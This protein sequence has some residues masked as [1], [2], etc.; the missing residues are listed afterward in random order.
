MIAIRFTC[1]LAR[2]QDEG[3]RY[4]FGGMLAVVLCVEA[5]PARGACE[6]FAPG[7]R[8]G[9]ATA[10]GLDEASGIA[11][12][13]RNAGILWTHND[14]A[15]RE[16]YALGPKG[17]LLA[18]YFLPQNVID[19]EDIAVGPGPQEGVSYLY[20]GDIGGN[21]GRRQ[22]QI[23]RIPEPLVDPGWHTHPRARGFAGADKFA[24][25]YPDGLYDAESLMVDPVSRDVFVVTKQAQGARVYRANV[26][27][28]SDGSAV[29][30]DFVRTVPFA[31]ASAADISADGSQIVFRREHFASIWEREEGES[32]GDALARP[33][34][35]IPVAAAEPNGEGIAFL[36]NGRGY[37]TMSEGEFPA[38]YSFRTRCPEAPQFTTELQDKTVN[39]KKTVT[40]RAKA[41]GY[42]KP[43][44]S[45]TFNGTLLSKQ[46]E[47]TLILRHVKSGQGGEYMVTAT[48]PY[49]TATS[50]ATLTVAAP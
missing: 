47:N 5:F 17:A 45:W 2:L 26:T 7:V 4:L 23:I 27:S 29:Q 11:S 42:P 37:V 34:K 18:T 32:V 24:L 8:I 28:R 40:F 31:R 10:D 19:K 12:S 39:P 36:A 49:G 9:T 41:S 6:L 30:M 25:T 21:D 46:K 15:G 16:V 35:R 13:R 50:A 38:I 3:L 48:N 22:V 43:R 20:I 14:G 1:V 33:G 44:Y